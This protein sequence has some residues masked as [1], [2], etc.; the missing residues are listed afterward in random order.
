MSEMIDKAGG[1]GTK[2]Y[3]YTMEEC[4]EIL[5]PQA[6]SLHASASRLGSELRANSVVFEATLLPN[7][8]ANSYFPEKLVRLLGLTSLGSRPANGDLILRNR[9]EVGVPTKSLIVAG[10]TE[11]LARLTRILE[12]DGLTR[13]EKAAA[14][15][16][17]KFSNIHL[18]RVSEVVKGPPVTTGEA[19]PRREAFEAILHPDPD[20]YGLARQPISSEVFHK[21]ERYIQGLGGEVASSSRDVVGGLTFV[22]VFLP[23]EKAIEAAE[24]NPLRSIR[25]MPR[26][27][28]VPALP[29]RSAPGVLRPAPAPASPHAPEVLIFDAGVDAHEDF[30]AGSVTQV[31]LTE[32]PSFPGCLEHGSA[33]T[34][35]VLYGR[36][37]VGEPLQSPQVRATHFRC[38]PG[39]DDEGVELYWLLD[40]IQKQVAESNAM[41]VNLSLGPEVPVDDGEPH[42]WTAVLDS[43]AYER[44]MLF[45]VAAGNNGS[46]PN[47]EGANRVQVPADMVNGLSVGA[48][49]RP[50]PEPLWSRS[51]YSA[52][53]PGRPGAMLQPSVLAFG[54]DPQRPFNRL[55][56]NGRLSFDWGTSYAAPLASHGLAKLSAEL[57][58]RSSSSA[59]RAFAIHFS[60]PHVNLKAEIETG[61]G[62]LPSDFSDALLC[63]DRQATVLYQASID[64]DQMLGFTLPV[65][66]GVN[67][68]KVKIKWTLAYASPTDPT[69]AV[70]YT[71]SGLEFTFRP[72]SNIYSFRDPD[73]PSRNIKVNLLEEPERVAEL[74]ESG[75]KKSLNPVSRSQKIGPKASESSRRRGGKWETVMQG[76][77]CLLAKS[78]SLP[79]LDIEFLTREG[80]QL[81]RESAPVDF[82]L[83][84]TVESLA[85]L[86][87]YG[88][89][90]VEFP[91]LS[92]LPVML[93]VQIRT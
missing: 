14:E 11:S 20:A 2:Y 1:G 24:F 32:R 74:V 3:P 78:L 16:L 70:E 17:R 48:C 37:E 43:L 12:S 69:E 9:T 89:A 46:E 91:V 5:A 92:E 85:G 29:L 26:I 67:R 83:V 61:H 81:T 73:T 64:R 33:V 60:E 84:V 19:H 15:E 79:R 75:W 45:V 55:S 86:P 34:G 66:E 76:Q 42:R 93:P 68:G 18:P 52:V 47:N 82:S 80:G 49:D 41:I 57:G 62:R 40:Q 56:G 58:D 51:E 13:P 38:I 28:P 23:P 54:G 88:M 65:P 63:T 44:D 59:L 4:R 22:P 35:A 7:F 71:E 72:H 50:H 21:F 25:K 87:V 39:H 90:K 6:R 36:V 10:S 27:R 53:G 31:D 8:L 30:F 77:D